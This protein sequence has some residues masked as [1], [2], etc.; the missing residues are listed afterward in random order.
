MLPLLAGGHGMLRRQHLRRGRFRQEEMRFRSRGLL[1]VPASQEGGM[2]RPIGTFVRARHQA[3]ASFGDTASLGYR[4]KLTFIFT[5]STRELWLCKRPTL[6]LRA[7]P[8]ETMRRARSKYE[9]WDCS[10]RRKIPRRCWGS[11]VA[12]SVDLSDSW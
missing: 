1:R 5:C 3:T 8:H 6:D 10:A 2:S 7:P 12:R 9:T 4:E 11:R